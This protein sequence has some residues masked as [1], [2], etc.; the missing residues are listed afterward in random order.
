MEEFRKRFT[1]EQLQQMMSALPPNAE[2]IYCGFENGISTGITTSVSRL[3]DAQMEEV[4]KTFFETPI[5]ELKLE[6]INLL[7]IEHK[8]PIKIYS[9]QK[10][11]TAGHPSLEIFYEVPNL[12]KC[13]RLAVLMKDR[14]YS[15]EFV[16]SSLE[17]PVEGDPREILYPVI[18]TMKI[19]D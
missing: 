19:K 3:Q 10:G 16:R 11:K 12:C 2:M 15:I 4:K 18:S 5:D 6:M 17:K 1:K 14:V 13:V 7:T 8:V 9:M